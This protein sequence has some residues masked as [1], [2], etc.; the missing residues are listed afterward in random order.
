M[1]AILGQQTQQEPP[2]GQQVPVDAMAEA[3]A[4]ALAKNAPRQQVQQ[5]QPQLSQE[6][7][8]QHFRT[9]R[10]SEALVEALFGEGATPQTR[11][12]ALS[13]ITQ[14]IVANATAH[15]NILA[16][17]HIQQYGSQLTPDLQELRHIADGRFFEELYDGAPGLKSDEPILREMMPTFKSAQDFPKEDRRA[18]PAYIRDKFIALRKQSDPN[19]DPTGGQQ[20]GQQTPPNV[21]QFPAQTSQQ[22][23]SRTQA[24]S[25]N[26][27]SG[28]GVN[29][30]NAASP[31]AGKTPNVGL[32]SVGF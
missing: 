17:H 5:Q 24:P 16:Q 23:I 6:E 10:P 21:R 22:S 31:A 13:H 26:S 27:L 3:F 18:Q 15:A 11:M 29:G 12:A 4:K 32:A 1:Q 8:D 9:F 14:G 20:P 7:M 19:Y 2:Q 30:G 25:P 28:G